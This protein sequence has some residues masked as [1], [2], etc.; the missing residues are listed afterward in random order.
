[1]KLVK[2]KNEPLTSN[3]RK[4]LKFMSAIT[5]ALPMF[6]SSG[7]KVFA[8]QPRYKYHDSMPTTVV[9]PMAEN[10]PKSYANFD[11]RL[12]Y[13]G[14]KIAHDPGITAIWQDQYGDQMYCT[15]PYMKTPHGVYNKGI[16]QGK[17]ETNPYALAVLRAGYPCKTPQELGVGNDTV[18]A[19]Y[20]TQLAVWTAMSKDKLASTQLMPETIKWSGTA[21]PAECL[22]VRDTYQKILADAAV[23]MTE[24][25]IT[26]IKLT[27][28]TQEPDDTNIESQDIWNSKCRWH[29]TTKNE[30]RQLETIPVKL[31]VTAND[32]PGVTKVWQGGKLVGQGTADASGHVT[33][34]AQVHSNDDIVIETPTEDH[35][36]SVYLTAET[37]RQY[38]LKYLG[39]P[40]KYDKH[41]QSSVS[42]IALKTAP[43][44]D[45]GSYILTAHTIKF[46]VHKADDRVK[47]GTGKGNSLAGVTFKL[48]RAATQAKGATDLG[49][50]IGAYTTNQ[51]GDFHT[52]GLKYG[53]YVLVEDTVPK[54]I[55]LDPT[56]KAVDCT[57]ASLKGTNNILDVSYGNITNQYND[58]HAT[59]TA[60]NL[61][62]NSQF[63]QPI[64]GPVI[65]N[66]QVH[67]SHLQT[68]APYKLHAWLMDRETG[69]PIIIDGKKIEVTKNFGS[70]TQDQ[71]PDGLEQDLD[72]QLKIPNASSL[73]GK[74]V[75]VF[76]EGEETEKTT[77][78]KK[79]TYSHKDLEDKAE[80][81]HF[82]KPQLHTKAVNKETGDNIL[83]PTDKETIVDTVRY[84]ELIP[85]KTYTLKGIVVDKKTGKAVMNNGKKVEFT[86]T[87]TAHNANGEVKAEVVFD[88]HHYWN[89]DLV[90]YETIY[91][92]GFELAR[93]RDLQ[94]QSQTLHVN[95]PRIHTTLAWNGQ[96]LSYPRSHNVAQDVI[97]YV[98]LIPGYR[99]EVR[100]KL[101][102]QV[103]GLPVQQNGM[104]VIATLSFKP[105]RPNG[106]V[107]ISF[108][109]NGKPYVGHNVVAFETLYVN[110]RVLL[111]H[112]DLNDASESMLIDHY[113]RNTVIP[114][115][116]HVHHIVHRGGATVVVSNNNNNN[117]NNNNSSNNSSN[118]SNNGN[119]SS[120]NSANSGM[121][122]G[123]NSYNG[124]NGVANNGTSKGSNSFNNGSNHS[125]SHSN[126]SSNSTKSDT[127]NETGNSATNNSSDSN[128][129]TTSNGSRHHAT[130]T[131]NE[132]STNAINHANATDNGNKTVSKFSLVP[133]VSATENIPRTI[134]STATNS[135][136]NVVLPQTGS[137]SDLFAQLIG[138]GLVT[139]TAG[140]A[141]EYIRRKDENAGMK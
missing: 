113:H 124:G 100:G 27:Q 129:Q 78:G 66:E 61:E 87:F 14:G 19:F 84:K 42:L 48:Y 2:D 76:C 127:N 83:H 91:Y 22:K 86:K 136:N 101:M 67:F 96:K 32:V 11:C 80:T 85:G 37:E 7:Y 44:V 139:L 111:E 36:A 40:G 26:S 59:S 128:S 41:E 3:E 102:D 88:A 46:R 99:Y 9:Y 95:H 39:V 34:S 94:D 81:I 93:H 65:I 120:S 5:L 72:V 69:K 114:I 16:Y 45:K 141:V 54:N 98:D 8:A 55:K 15:E 12:V 47:K 138:I 6:L 30:N 50:Y 119:N 117:N 21:T 103:T 43:V 63:A 68:V 97:R 134:L 35:D 29:I 31:N 62:D 123:S 131:V 135:G 17:F 70:K 79:Y 137:K 122:N 53:Y 24:K 109:F 133:K 74:D 125:S 58:V 49:K 73:A 18:A 10:N 132:I 71:N 23:L 25:P 107:T 33:I 1:M 28:I 92:T 51:K 104:P 75:V 20:A 64:Q 13:Q 89:R 56:P 108:K 140:A 82:S 110:G 38:E 105:N 106:T 115:L 52:E 77:D 57:Y 4:G 116:P 90:V 118:N 121:N 130:A 60:T 112:S 126:N